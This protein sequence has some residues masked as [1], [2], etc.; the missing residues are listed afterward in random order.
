MWHTGLVAPGMWD[1]PGPGNEP[2]SPALA[3]RFLSTAPPGKPSFYFLD[4][5]LYSRKVLNFDE[6]QLSVFSAVAC[7][8]GVIS[9]KT[10]SNP[11]S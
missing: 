10:L 5:V 11:R 3:G 4:G 1:L 6:V 8:F 9:K 2:V 7:A